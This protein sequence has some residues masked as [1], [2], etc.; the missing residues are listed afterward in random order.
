[1]SVY[2]IQA[3]ALGPIKIGF[4]ENVER[5]L[6]KM[7]V[8]NHELLTIL[9][10]IKDG[11]RKVEESLHERFNGSRLSGEWFKPCSRLVGFIASLPAYEAPPRKQH[12]NGDTPVG[13]IIDAFGGTGKTAKRF[14]VLP[15]AVSNWRANEQFPARLHYRIS[16]DAAK[17]GININPSVFKAKK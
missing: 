6:G 8:D 7:R 1:M 14:D 4:A 2:F 12:L 17:E 3:G 15:S 16:L 10:V 5:R 11:C 9:A 13:R